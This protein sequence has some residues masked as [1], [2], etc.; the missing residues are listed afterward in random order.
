[1]YK[2]KPVTWLIMQRHLPLK[3]FNPHSPWKGRNREKIAQTCP[4]TSKYAPQCKYPLMHIMEHT[5]NAIT[6]TITT[7]IDDDNDDDDYDKLLKSSSPF[8]AIE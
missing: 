2:V 8:S 4:L 6:V 1:M 7:T 5:H 3:D